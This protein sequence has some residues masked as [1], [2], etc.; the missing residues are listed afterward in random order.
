MMIYCP[1]FSQIWQQLLFARSW[2]RLFG[3]RP[4]FYE[5]LEMSWYNISVIANNRAINYQNRYK[6]KGE[7]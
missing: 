4:R 3:E 7:Q 1:V 6:A 2:L 5:E